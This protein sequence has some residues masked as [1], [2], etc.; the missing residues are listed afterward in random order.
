MEKCEPATLLALISVSAQPFR[1]FK[2]YP[3]AFM[4]IV[5]SKLG[6]DQMQAWRF[7][8]AV[9]TRP[10]D[11]E[12]NQEATDSPWLSTTL[13]VFLEYW[14]PPLQPQSIP[15]LDGPLNVL[16]KLVKVQ[17]AIN[18]LQQAPIW[19]FQ[20]DDL[21]YYTASSNEYW[22][23]HALWEIQMFCELFKHTIS[24][25]PMDSIRHPSSGRRTFLT[26]MQNNN[27][28]GHENV[29]EFVFVYND[30]FHLL[31]RTYEQHMGT[32][33]EY[34]YVANI[35]DADWQEDP[36]FELPGGGREKVMHF[37]MNGVRDRLH[38]QMLLGLPFLAKTYRTLSNPVARDTIPGLVGFSD[39]AL[40]SLHGHRGRRPQEYVAFELFPCSD[41]LDGY[42]L[43]WVFQDCTCH[44]LRRLDFD[45]RLFTNGYQPPDLGSIEEAE[46]KWHRQI[47][48]ED[49]RSLH[50]DIDV[51]Q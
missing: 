46:Q 10:R 26:A 15:E 14:F 4:A 18:T 1:D 51:S 24:F 37:M 42:N 6:Y 16:A 38:A 39:D 9:E 21:E 47:L 31:E 7:L 12:P 29:D 35:H 41:G 40:S 22:L 32:V 5:W 8:K 27:F 20:A 44:P 49:M 45:Y 11:T 36:A 30:L 34:S 43:S 23:R 3:K 33:F 19:S 48:D 25:V 28:D 17:T 2:Q 13:D 50:Y